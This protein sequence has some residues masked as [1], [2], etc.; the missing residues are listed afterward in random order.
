MSCRRVAVLAFALLSLGSTAVRAQIP[1]TR[2]MIP[3]RTQLARVGLERQWIAVVALS[4]TERVLRVSRSADL[5]FAQTNNGGLHA[6]DAETGKLRWTASLGGYTPF[7]RPISSNSYAVFGTVGETLIGFDKNKGRVIWRLS[8]GAIPTSGTVADEDR[9]LVGTAEGRL[10]AY[11]LRSRDAKGNPT[12]RTKPGMEWGWQTSGPV[13]TLPLMA[14]HVVAFG[15]TDG[16]V[17]VVLNDQQITLYRIRTGGKIG[18]GLGA[19][20]TRTLLIPSADKN[21]YAVDLLTAQNQWVFPSGSPILQSPLVAGEDILTIN[22]AGVLSSLEPATGT[23][24]WSIPTPEATLLSLSPTR[25]YLRSTNQDLIVVDRTAGKL[26]ADAA[27]TRQRAGLNLRDFELSMLNRYD[28][29]L[30]LGTS[31]GIVVCLREIGA[32]EPKLL[33]DPKALP[34]GYIPPEGL[35]K[36]PAPAATTEPGA[37]GKESENKDSAGDAAA[38]P[39]AKPDAEPKPDADAPEAEKSESEKP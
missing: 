5:I 3:T 23:P 35:K 25:V 18:D 33:R 14:Q 21:L 37:E 27:A 11:S 1:Y 26:L 13:D 34:F 10:N 7:A 16:R 28:D 36:P 17:Y 24:K 31:S 2:D 19:Y 38:D 30:C 8:L 12:I 9:V 20:G 15:S 32:T 22:E 4:E 6:F 29:R 39:A